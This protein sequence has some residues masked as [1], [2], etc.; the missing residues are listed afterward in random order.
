M[1]IVGEHHVVQL[2][3][4]TAALEIC[5]DTYAAEALAARGGRGGALSGGAAVRR[6][7]SHCANHSLGSELTGSIDHRGPYQTIAGRRVGRRRVARR[8]SMYGPPPMEPQRPG[9]RSIHSL[10]HR[11]PRCIDRRQLLA[12]FE[13]IHYANVQNTYSTLTITP[14]NRRRDVPTTTR[15][16]RILNDMIFAL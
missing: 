2:H 4:T 8:P 16:H 7:R 11:I 5:R 14:R 6:R 13:P 15:K 9:T 12:Q 1:S 3:P 10:L